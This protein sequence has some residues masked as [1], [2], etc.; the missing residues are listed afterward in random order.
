MDFVELQF[1]NAFH[2]VDYEVKKPA[3]GIIADLR[4]KAISYQEAGNVS[5]SEAHHI[6]EKLV[7]IYYVLLSLIEIRP[8]THIISQ[9][10]QLIW[11]KE[12]Q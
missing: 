11:K 5:N 7:P 3:S 1:R 9:L 4:T 6:T 10:R 2:K 8:L 12:P